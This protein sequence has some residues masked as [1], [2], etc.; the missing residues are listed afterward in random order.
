MHNAKRLGIVQR[1]LGGHLGSGCECECKSVSEGF[2]LIQ[3]CCSIRASKFAQKIKKNFH[4]NQ[5]QTAGVVLEF[6]LFSLC[7]LNH[8]HGIKFI[9]FY[10]S[11]S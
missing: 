11:G 1:A 2:L 6:G 8:D 5:Q 4:K 9:L 7:E 3:Y 10:S